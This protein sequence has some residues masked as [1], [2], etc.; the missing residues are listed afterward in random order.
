MRSEVEIASRQV[1]LP[2]FVRSE[3]ASETEA[4]TGEGSERRGTAERA[5]SNQHCLVSLIPTVSGGKIVV[6]NEHSRET[7]HGGTN[8]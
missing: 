4:A 6:V 8:S 5:L 7:T 1:G 3:L 2:S